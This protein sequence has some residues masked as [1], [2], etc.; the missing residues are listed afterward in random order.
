MS[1]ISTAIGNY[2]IEFGLEL[3][4]AYSTAPSS[5]GSLAITPTW[6]RLG[7]DPVYESTV[8]APGGSGSWKFVTD[9]T[10]SCRLNSN[11][12]TLTARLNDYDYTAGVWVKF[13]SIPNTAGAGTTYAFVAMPTASTVGFSMTLTPANGVYYIGG[14][15]SGNASTRSNFAVNSNDWYLVTARRV[16][17]T[18]SYAVNGITFYT[19]T[20][21]NTGTASNTFLG[22]GSV[23]TT[24]TL[25][26]NLSNFFISTASAVTE[27]N[28]KTIYDAGRAGNV[29][30]YSDAVTTATAEFLDPIFK[31]GS[32]LNRFI[33]GFAIQRGI[34][35]SEPYAVTPTQTGSLSPD[36]IY[37]SRVGRDPVYQ[38]S[39]GPAGGAGSW[40]FRSNE[41]AGCRIRNSGGSAVVAINDGDFSSGAWFK[42]NSR[43]ATNGENPS[44]HSHLP[45]TTAGYDIKFNQQ[46]SSLI[47]ATSASEYSVPI[48]LG[49]W[50]YVA[51]RKVGTQVKFFLNGV[52]QTTIT[53]SQTAAGNEITWGPLAPY[54]ST[55]DFSMNLSNYYL[56]PSSE[57]TEAAIS[58]IYNIGS[59][60][61][62]D[63][64]SSA[65]V[66]KIRS[67]NPTVTIPFDQAYNDPY[68]QYVVGAGVTATTAAEFTIPSGYTAPVQELGYAPGVGGWKFDETSRTF[69]TNATGLQ[70]PSF[71]FSIGTWAKVNQWGTGGTFFDI[72]ENLN[73]VASLAYEIDT[74]VG[75]ATYGKRRFKGTV[76]GSSNASDYFGADLNLL[77]NEW[78]YLAVSIS[79]GIANYYVNGNLVLSRNG[80]GYSAYPSSLRFGDA[81][82]GSFVLSNFYKSLN[83]VIDSTAIKAIYDSRKA[84]SVNYT[85]TPAE[86]DA[87]FISQP[88]NARA[89]TGLAELLHPVITVVVGNSV[90][91]TTSFA[92]DAT[93]VEP[94]VL[95]GQYVFVAG[96]LLGTADAFME[97]PFQIETEKSHSVSASVSTATAL[98]GNHKVAE[99]PLI[100]TATLPMPV[101]ATNPNYFKLVTPY[102]PVLYVEDGQSVVRN[103]GSWGPITRDSYFFTFDVLAGQ[104][105]QAVG[106]QKSWETNAI[107]YG[108]YP[109][110]EFQR[111]DYKTTME[112]LYATRTLSLEF[113]YFSQAYITTGTGNDGE[114]GPLFDDGVTLITESRRNIN[115]RAGQVVDYNS[116]ILYGESTH[117][118]E[119]EPGKDYYNFREYPDAKPQSQDWN[120]VVITYEPNVDATKTRRYVYLNGA[121][122]DN[123]LL[124]MQPSLNVGAYTL[125]TNVLAT[126][127]AAVY[128]P[129]T[130]EGYRGPRIAGTIG[131]SG[132]RNF[133][134]AK[135]VKFDEIAIYPVTL[136]G[137][138]IIDHYSFIKSLSPNTSPFSNSI[139]VS[140]EMGNH[141]VYPVINFVYE[142]T[143]LTAIAERITEPTLALGYD[144]IL[145]SSPV[146]ASATLVMPVVTFS[147]NLSVSPMTAS[148]EQPHAFFLND[149]YYNYVQ[150]NI[151][152]YRYATFDGSNPDLDY[153]SDDDYAVAPFTYGGT[154]VNP[155]EGINGK[156][157]K[158]TGGSY[159]TDGLIMK[160]SVHD[161]TWGT[162]AND[163]HSSFWMQRA[164]DDTSTT[165]LRVLWNV[166]GQNDNQHMVLY[167]YQNKL[168]LQINNQADA[169]VTVSSANNV[170][171]FNYGINHFVIYFNH[172]GNNHTIT[173]YVNGTSV[174]TQNIGTL[175]I[176]T[177]N[178]SAYTAANSEA[179][180]F[181]RLSV[182]CLITPFGST[183]LPVAPTN[184]KLIID[185]VYWDKNDITNG[186][187]T[188]L[189]NAMPGR[190]NYVAAPLPLT[191][192]A[193]SVM[194]TNTTTALYNATPATDF[195]ELIHPL[196]VAVFNNVITASPM[197]ANATGAGSSARIDNV[198][199]VAA[200]MLA[201]AFIGG[202]GT[203]RVVNGTPMS[204]TVTLANR[205]I[206]DG[207]IKVNGIKI[208]EPQSA[209]VQYV[210]VTNKNNLVPMNGVK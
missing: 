104:E 49:N 163:W 4:E 69:D 34:Q 58:E 207:G 96:V 151:A 186:Q 196:V 169:P 42:I 180:N 60:R 195:S 177:I 140:A 1:A 145:S 146:T 75:S 159:A 199:I 127:I 64:I 30:Y 33:N 9:T 94:V 198:T 108:E 205:T 157:L 11:N 12:A 200:L 26:Y 137:S 6:T 52:L 57:V 87:G 84:L 116:V 105:M 86:A 203:P 114:S 122:V 24:G 174:L 43:D 36:T 197:T 208:F 191:V 59:Y 125:N 107:N 162:G 50:Y 194:P 201:S 168:H 130:G 164:L 124:T 31:L 19:E 88:I 179:S 126:D 155:G 129:E 82:G 152:P 175:Q 73:T 190:T 5:T 91:S 32:D 21:T 132:S 206:F 62:N 95:T 15:T 20:R 101:V 138:T 111:S 118:W 181:P 202:A 2:S 56:A 185:E 83:S 147:S 47:F 7:R 72:R 74:T 14:L 119:N 210:K 161:D 53:Q 113:W 78:Y 28:V 8:N 121:I 23:T 90:N 10:A 172:N 71:N 81:N 39:V 55:S 25:S 51:V 128:G 13:N 100:A 80:G 115:G 65:V 171:V 142:E 45:S 46:T 37:F 54:T 97:Q 148:G 167:H 166:N 184:T 173:V 35:F 154:V 22:T 67:Y 131:F 133:S 134:T 112:A 123:R 76:Y 204:A 156:A 136:S 48:S 29:S 110:L 109:L 27:A 17:T 150:T 40:L 85:A 63:Y 189:Y 178:N 98:M 183:A 192:D 188:S 3:N 187:V 99:A 165:G 182:G 89:L 153:G 70:I 66:Q 92:I 193:L 176:T 160:E 141:Q 144:K 18:M 158:T 149:V 93:I 139:N 16:G 44:I 38:P 77:E 170:D 120:H 102:T 68:T 61:E 79:G 143:P 41:S 103:Y 106:N 209:W 117:V 135:G